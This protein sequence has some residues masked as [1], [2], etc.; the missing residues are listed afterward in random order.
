LDKQLERFKALHP[1]PHA[2]AQLLLLKSALLRSYL[3][4]TGLSPDEVDVEVLAKQV[5]HALE[6]GRFDLPERAQG[7]ES[8]MDE[9]VQIWIQ[10]REDPSVSDS[11]ELGDLRVRLRDAVLHKGESH[12]TMVWYE[13]AIAGLCADSSCCHRPAPFSLLGWS[14]LPIDPHFLWITEF[15][16]FTRADSD[17]AV[18]SGGR[19]AS[20]HHPFTAPMHSHLPALQRILSSLASSPS[21]EQE[22]EKVLAGF[23]SWLRR[24]RGQHYDLVLNG[25]EIGGG[26][27]RIHSAHLQSSVLRS[28]HQL[29]SGEIARFAHLL[30]ALDSGCPPHAGIALGF[31]RLV[32]L[33]T[34]RES[35]SIRDVIAFPKIGAAGRDP[36]FGS[37]SPIG[38]TVNVRNGAGGDKSKKQ[39]S[40]QSAQPQAQS[41]TAVPVEEAIEDALALEEDSGDNGDGSLPPRT[42][43][44]SHLSS[45][46]QQQA[47]AERLLLSEFGLAR[48]TPHLEEETLEVR[49]RFRKISRA[50]AKRARRAEE[51]ERVREEEREREE[52]MRGRGLID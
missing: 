37:P 6:K 38:E 14:T 10:R 9:E 51:E 40:G 3:S 33:L 26:S 42:S 28:I 52:R 5:E 30:G 49:S 13:V 50:K 45:P 16:L 22:Q 36:L 23:E 7:S 20:T 32:S 48:N 24:I 15:P 31:D 2:I 18:L 4:D 47:A 46:Q 11:T 34:E 41:S 21:S 43:P 39:V 12:S 8:E 25:V 17:K 44:P 1:A 27:V 19:W 35:A 29:S